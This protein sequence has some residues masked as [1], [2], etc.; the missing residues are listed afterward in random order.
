MPKMPCAGP[1]ITQMLS[2]PA[3]SSLAETTFSYGRYVLGDYRL[4]MN[5]ERSEQLILSAARF[6]SKSFNK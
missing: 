1:V 6:K 5:P 2:P 4:S 3:A